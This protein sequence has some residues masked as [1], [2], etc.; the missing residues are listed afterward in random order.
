MSFWDAVLPTI[1]GAAGGFIAGGPIGAIAGGALGYAGYESNERNNR[2]NRQSAQEQMDF[3]KHMSDTAH[4]REAA[5]L[6]AA[7]LNPN[8]SG[9]GGNGS[10]SP[11]GAMA[12][13]APPQ[14]SFPEVL[15]VKALHQTDE[16]I[17]LEKAMN[18]ANIAKTMSETDIN[19]M[20]RILKQKGLLRA[21]AE[22][23]LTKELKGLMDWANKRG[24]KKN[25]GLRKQYNDFF[26][27]DA[28]QYRHQ[29]P[30]FNPY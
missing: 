20:E 26:Q 10:S 6:R 13:S 17:R 27:P 23:E 25:D 3:Q 1:G 11:G 4:Q 15:Q 9:T 30:N 21:E 2:R 29:M 5:D 18:A 8:L 22:G 24:K 7:G 14:I 19:K 28:P 16:R 12:M